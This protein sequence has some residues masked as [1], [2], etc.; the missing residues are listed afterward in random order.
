MRIYYFGELI[1]DTN[2]PKNEIEEKQLKLELEA[3]PSMS[4]KA[5]T[6]IK[7]GMESIGD[8]LKELNLNVDSFRSQGSYSGWGRV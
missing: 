6:K 7:V 5:N 1:E 8:I 3:S 4:E 2:N